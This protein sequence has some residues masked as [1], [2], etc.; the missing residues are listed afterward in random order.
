MTREGPQEVLKF[1]DEKHIFK[2]EEGIMMVKLFEA[3]ASQL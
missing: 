1:R 3:R 2:E